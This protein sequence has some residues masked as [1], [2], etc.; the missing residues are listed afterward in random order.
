MIQ[1]RVVALESPHSAPLTRAKSLTPCTHLPGFLVQPSL[2]SSWV[3]G[4]TF[5]RNREITSALYT[6]GGAGSSCFNSDAVGRVLFD[7]AAGCLTGSHAP[8]S[9]IFVHL[10]PLLMHDW[11]FINRVMNLT[12]ILLIMW[13]PQGGLASPKCLYCNIS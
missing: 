8:G 11:S 1:P 10:C 13:C 6:S 3:V 5:V 12:E 4:Q 7:R 9:C 2:P